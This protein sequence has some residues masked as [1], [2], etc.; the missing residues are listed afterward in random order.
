MHGEAEHGEDTAA[1]QAADTDRSDLPIAET[2]WSLLAH[3]P[4][5]LI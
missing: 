5:P 2:A 3:D 4:N 1:D